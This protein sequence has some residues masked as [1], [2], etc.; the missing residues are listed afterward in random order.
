MAYRSRDIRNVALVGHSACGK[1]TLA[2]AILFASG[3]IKK[4]GSVED[5]STV[6]DHTE[7]AKAAR[8]S[9]EATPLWCDWDGR[10]INL[11]D[12]PGYAD[13]AGAQIQAL[14]AVET[15]VIVVNGTTGVEVTTR[16]VW[17]RLQSSDLARVIAVSKVDHE[18]ADFAGTLE[19]L[20]QA[21]GPACAAATVPDGDGVVNL[22]SAKDLTDE[23]A[24]M[25][26]A[27]IESVISSDD[28]LL[29]RYLEE[30]EVSDEELAKV[31]SKALLSGTVVPVFAVASTEGR[32]VKELLDFLARFA[33]D[34]TS[35]KR[36]VVTGEGET[37]IEPEEDGFFAAQVFKVTSSEY[38]GKVGFLRVYSGKLSAG[39]DVHAPPSDRTER[40]GKLYRYQGE[41]S[42]EMEEAAAGDI[43]ATS[44][45]SSISFGVTYA[46]SAD[47]PPFVR[48]ELPVP[49]LSRAVRP[50]KPGDEGKITDALRRLVEEDPTF[51]FRQDPQTKEL[52]VSGLGD[53]HLKLIFDRL[54][55]RFNLELEISIPKIPYRETIT[56]DADV[57]YRHKKQTGGAGQFAEVAMRVNP[58]E[59]GGG[60]EFFDDVAGRSVEPEFRPSVN[61]GC[62]KQVAE[63]VLGGYPVVD[64]EVHLYD[65]KT[66]TVDSSDIAF[67]IAAREAFKRAVREA[68]PMFLEPVVN[69][70][71][72]APARYMGD[73]AGDI[74][75]RRGRLMGMEQQGEMQVVKAQAPLAEVQTYSSQL[76]SITAGE[77]YFTM[78][79]SHY[80]FVPPNVAEKIVQAARKARSE[81]Q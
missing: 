35:V 10:R 11:I 51:Q 50:K 64:I 9:V 32:G 62:Q 52:V 34:P 75:G 68:K 24:K 66:H 59:R 2:E 55:R 22:I 60:Y 20:R 25:R 8:R 77:G 80:D 72:V 38:V 23:R 14:S 69:I 41:S 27:L 70:D 18:N 36:K 5:G 21:F 3:A 47:A 53:A 57:R 63:G 31:F 37:E 58:R 40:V 65:G 17:Q 76:Q 15:V 13:F 74:N 73:I 19:Q 45:L 79:F 4:M 71:I 56:V 42:E 1:T 46:A 39:T 49:L 33:P 43:V 16:K 61:K 48:P 26:E 44:K 78:E 67:Q 29:E 30:G 28:S 12:S 81:E 54:K 7:E 6:S